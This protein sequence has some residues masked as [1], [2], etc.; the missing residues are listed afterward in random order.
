M[1]CGIVQLLVDMLSDSDADIRIEAAWAVCNATSG[2]TAEQID[3]LVAHGVIRPLL[4]LCAIDVP[5]YDSYRAKYQRAIAADAEGG[6]GG[7]RGGQQ[8][9]TAPGRASDGAVSGGTSK[10]DSADI[11]DERK[12]IPVGGAPHPLPSAAGGAARVPVVG[13]KQP[14]SSAHIAAAQHE[15]QLAAEVTVDLDEGRRSTRKHSAKSPLG[16]GVGGGSFSATK[17]DGG[18]E[19]APSPGAGEQRGGAAV[20]DARY[21]LAVHAH[22]DLVEKVSAVASANA[23]ASARLTLPS[24]PPHILP[25]PRAPRRCYVLHALAVHVRDERRDGRRRVVR[26]GSAARRCGALG[27]RRL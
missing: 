23:S 12:I 15:A 10:W 3:T 1:E 7:G 5:T 27:G 22:S 21:E 13:L 16:S 18:D 20:A 14:L 19:E 11:H 26:R 17:Q 25:R 2:G 6:G 8:T 24:P 4:S 9:A